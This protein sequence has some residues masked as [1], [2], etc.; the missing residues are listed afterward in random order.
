MYYVYIL[1]SQLIDKYYI[2]YSAD[3]DGRLYKHIVK[4]KG[5]TAQVSDWKMV[6]REPFESKIEAMSREKQL[7]KWKS[8]VAIENLIRSIG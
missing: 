4:H 3:A 7:K 5:F 6:Y 8:R 1:Y 2:G